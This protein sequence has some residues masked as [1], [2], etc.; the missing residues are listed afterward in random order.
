M[1]LTKNFIFFKTKD[2]F[3]AAV[4]NLPQTSIVF[5]KDTPIIWTHGVTYDVSAGVQS[6]AVWTKFLAGIDA[7]NPAP[8]LADIKSRLEALEGINHDAY[9]AADNALKSSLEGYADQA[10]ADAI[11]AANAY[12]D[13]EINK[14]TTGAGYATT[15]YVDE[16]VSAVNTKFNNYSTT[17]QMDEQID[18]DVL[19]E[20]NRATAA[21]NALG[22]R[23]DA[24]STV[25]EAA[26]TVAEVNSQI[27]SK[28]SALKLGE[29]YE[30]I[31]A[32]SRANTYTNTKVA[33]KQ[34]IIDDLETIRTNASIAK[35]WVDG[36][37]GEDADDAI[38]KWGEV[39]SF[40]ADIEDTQ[41]LDG[42]L[43]G[44][45]QSIATA[46]ST[47]KDAQT[48]S[49]GVASDLNEYKTTVS[50]T[51]ATQS[52]VSDLTEEVAGKYVKPTNGIPAKDLDDDVNTALT[53]ANTAVQPSAISDMATKTFTEATYQKIG[54]Y[55]TVDQITEQFDTLGSAEVAKNEAISAATAMWEWGYPE[56]E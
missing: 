8:T 26:T 28:I 37:T 43:G 32:E 13:Q 50:N 19:V 55:A 42:I 45:N 39:V 9:I 38:N 16:V 35:A 48:H 47:A 56:G 22:E 2:A 17:T 53:K 33:E 30:P 1:A 4:N 5:V 14:I 27:D 49:E 20:T 7:S 51:Y 52:T 24:V 34:D 21:E 54:N 18:A 3:D 31:G 6:M 36:V 46:Q 29:T 12:T 25:A 23:I 10:E 40:L 44:I 41:T 15:K 11:T